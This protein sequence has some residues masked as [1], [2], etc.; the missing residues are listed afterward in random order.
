MDSF[1]T[2]LPVNLMGTSLLA[3]LYPV[4]TV[5]SPTVVFDNIGSSFNVSI[6][7]AVI[8]IVKAVYPVKSE[9][10]EINP[11]D[12][13]DLVFSKESK[14][15]TVK[16][17]YSSSALYF[18]TSGSSGGTYTLNLSILTLNRK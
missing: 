3:N 7:G 14:S 6:A 5:M 1:I 11:S 15:L 17:N 10:I 12:N 8:V 2:S 18:M 9:W 4:R 13:Y 16:W